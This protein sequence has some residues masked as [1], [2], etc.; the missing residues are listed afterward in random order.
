MSKTTMVAPTETSTNIMTSPRMLKKLFRRNSSSHTNTAAAG[1]H[2]SSNEPKDLLT[3][4]TTGGGVQQ[5][6]PNMFQK[7]FQNNNHNKFNDRTTQRSTEQNTQQQQQQEQSTQQQQQK[8]NPIATIVLDKHHP[9]SPHNYAYVATTNNNTYKTSTY[10]N[11]SSIHNNNNNNNRASLYQWQDAMEQQHVRAQKQRVKERDGFCRRVSSYD[12]HVLCCRD[13]SSEDIPVYELGH[14]LG[15]GVA[16][17]VY[18]GHR[19]RPME[20]YPVRWGDA[21]SL[22]PAAMV[23]V[24]QQHPM[25]GAVSPPTQPPIPSSNYC[26][27]GDQTNEPAEVSFPL[28]TTTSIINNNNALD[29]DLNDRVNSLLTMQDTLDEGHSFRTAT[30]HYNSNNYYEQQTEQVA[31]EATTDQMIMIDTVD[32]PSRSNHYARAI[33]AQQNTLDMDDCGASVCDASLCGGMEETVAIKVLNPVGFRILSADVTRSALVVRTGSSFD[34]SS[35]M[36]ERHVWWLAHPNSRNLQTLRRYNTAA[37]TQRRVQVDRGT[38]D[39]GL[40]LSLIAAYSDESGALLELPLT[41]CIEIWGHVPFSASDDEFQLLMESIDKINQGQQPTSTSDVQQQQDYSSEDLTASRPMTNKARTYVQYRIYM[42]CCLT[43]A[44]FFIHML[45]IST[46]YDSG[47]YRAAT[48]E[49]TTVYCDEL[50]AYIALPAVPSKYLKWLRQRR[51]AT[52]EIRNMMLIGRHR[53]VVHLFEVLEYIQE[54]KSTMF[55]ILELVRGGELF[56][57]IS[58]NAAK[59]SH[60]D[61]IPL[62]FTESE[63]VMRKFFFE[64][65]SGVSYC[66]NNGIA[67][68]DLKPE[69]L[70]VHNSRSGVG[71]TLKIADFGLSAA[72]GPS[73]HMQTDT[74]TITESLAPLPFGA[75]PRGRRRNDSEVSLRTSPAPSPAAK[76]VGAL[77]RAG[78]SVLSFLT[79]GVMEDI[80]DCNYQPTVADDI[81]T[82]PSTLKRMTS[83][84]G[85][86]HYVAPEIISQADKR[87]GKDGTIAPVGYDGTKADVWSAGVILYAMLFRSLPFGEDLLRC[88]RYQSFKSWYDEV[89][90]VKGRRSVAAAAL[91][92]LITEADER[93]FLGPHWFFPSQSS[94]ESRDLI[95]FMLNPNPD[96]RPSIQLVLQHPWLLKQA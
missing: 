4:A 41:K 70:L 90:K 22:V 21:D 46:F 45:T 79:C 19:L 84:V 50:K 18:E 83:V 65:A 58:S 89:I 34:G 5:K 37:S 80:L 76:D 36:E 2:S 32:A 35:A 86:P 61:K 47:I 43:D 17:V 73:S 72:F 28:P 23:R 40:R 95:V 68:R 60:D 81:D 26:C 14:Y 25:N 33:I 15:G 39:K 6:K 63:T 88:P 9:G 85:S 67:H 91:D 87:R 11:A 10:N 66:H 71:C 52:K 93:D 42:R 31:L 30:T 74:D 82:E 96:A 69:N 3:R 59:I 20:E 24:P 56:D 57:L 48:S 55:L 49:R 44:C 27:A 1:N 92:P 16:G 75:S 8:N 51:A 29:D 7:A 12:G 54:T 13:G 77:A 62:G 38:A 78:G 53:N 64:L 94:P